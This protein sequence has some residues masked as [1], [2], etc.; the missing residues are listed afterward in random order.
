MKLL[1]YHCG[2]SLDALSLPFAR[3]DT[4]PGCGRYVHACRMCR[5]FDTAETSK[6]C[7]EDDA[8]KLQDKAAAN[9]CDYFQPSPSAHEDSALR[10]ER[11]A[12]NRLSA[13]FGETTSNEL[14]ESAESAEDQARRHAESLFRK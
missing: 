6:Q 9:F 10:A 5:F 7:R 8:E 13:L 4:C 14:T 1:C 3:L 2:I 12:Q 11:Q